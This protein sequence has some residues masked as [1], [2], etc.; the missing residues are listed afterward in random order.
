MEPSACQFLRDHGLTALKNDLGIIVKT[1]PAY[2]SLHFLKYN[3]LES[4][5][6]HSVVRDSRGLMVDADRDWSPVSFPFRKFFNYGEGNADAIDWSTAQSME[7]LDGSLMTVYFHDGS[8][9]VAS[10][11]TP[12]AGGSVGNGYAGTFAELWWATAGE[13]HHH[14]DTRYCY[15]FE[16][17]SP[18]NRIIVQHAAPHCALIGMRDMTT[19]LEVDAR[20]HA[21]AL[22][23]HHAHTFDLSSADACQSAAEALA[24]LEQEGFVVRD[25]Q[26]NRVKIKS[27]RYVALHHMRDGFSERRMLE[28][29]RRGEGPEFLTYFPEFQSMYTGMTATYQGL[30][31][32]IDRA[33]FGIH[34]IPDQKA[35]AMEAQKTPYASALFSL[36]AKKYPDVQSLLA[37]APDAWL[38]RMVIGDK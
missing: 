4:P 30:A 9:H 7:K 5:M 26:W 16:L 34:A 36:R 31:M 6:S 33:Y 14:L 28:L 32:A 17:M 13:I 1:H 11:G 19:F 3:Q 12:D 15:M 23:L 10:N 27:P 2:P 35:F 29:V 21:A 24:P 18:F 22:G 8:W 25:A 37:S 38:Q 20:P